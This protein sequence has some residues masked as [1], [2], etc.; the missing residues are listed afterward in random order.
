MSFLVISMIFSYDN[1][2]V[3][4][5]MCCLV[6]KNGMRFLYGI[7]TKDMCSPEFGSSKF[8]VLFLSS[9]LVIYFSAM[10]TKDTYKLI[11]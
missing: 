2:K 10:T 7:M 1:N 9:F 4:Q 3:M 8:N 6:V 5:R 11:M